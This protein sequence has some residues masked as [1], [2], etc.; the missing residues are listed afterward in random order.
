V[1]ISPFIPL[2]GCIAPLAGMLLAWVL[3]RRGIFHAAQARAPGALTRFLKSACGFDAVYDLLLVRPYLWLVRVLRGDPVDLVFVGL[4]R[5]AIA[6]HRGLRA[7]QNG[8][9]RRYA[10]LLMAGSLATLAMLLFA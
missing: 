4:E 7:T 10:G 9:L 6:A 8:R 3:Y 5:L 2:A 1:P